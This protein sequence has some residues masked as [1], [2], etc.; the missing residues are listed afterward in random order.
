MNFIIG[1]VPISS[2]MFGLVDTGAVLNT[3]NMD[4]H[5]SV[6]ERHPNLVL[7]FA[8]LKDLNNVDPFNLSVLDRGK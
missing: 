2:N 5:Q 4:Y 6:V 8:Y 1:E 3:E 7:E